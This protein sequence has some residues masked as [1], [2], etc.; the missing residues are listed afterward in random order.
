[1]TWLGDP[2]ELGGVEAG[3]GATD[4]GARAK[5]EPSAALGAGRSPGDQWL[6]QL[7][8]LASPFGSDFGLLLEHDVQWAGD[9]FV[10]LDVV[11]ERVER[12]GRL[13]WTGSVLLATG[14]VSLLLPLSQ[15]SDWGWTDAKAMMLLAA[16]V[17][18]LAGFGWT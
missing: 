9:V 7:Q 12:G 8:P 11:D 1:V 16:A 2:G 17:V 4:Q 10:L 13:D 14:L 6:E 18:I 3:D 15:G 5:V